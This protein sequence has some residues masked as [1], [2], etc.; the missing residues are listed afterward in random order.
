MFGVRVGSLVAFAAALGT[1]ASLLFATSIPAAA[2]FGSHSQTSPAVPAVAGTMVGVSPRVDCGGAN[3]VIAWDRGG[4]QTWGQAWASCPGSSVWIYLAW[5]S[6][7][8][9]N[10]PV[11]VVAY[12]N[13][14]GFNSGRIGTLLSPG[15][16][17]ITACSNH[18]S[19]HCGTPIS[20]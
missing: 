18:N 12:P 9:H 1:A 20:V 5:D 16:I 7:T 17:S 11:E 10:I 2:A 3:G 13:S 8:H 15:H 19:W 14:L 6:P 4:I